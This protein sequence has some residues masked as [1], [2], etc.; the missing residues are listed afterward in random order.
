MTPLRPG[1]IEKLVAR[2]LIAFPPS[3][4]DAYR[5]MRREAARIGMQKLRD[6]KKQNVSSA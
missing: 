1:D 5:K 2:R 4:P 3:R 6:R